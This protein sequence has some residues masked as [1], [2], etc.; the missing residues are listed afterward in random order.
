VK[1]VPLIFQG[2]GVKAILDGRKT[3]TRRIK[4]SGQPG[5]RIWVKETWRDS[6]NALAAEAAGPV[7]GSRFEGPAYEYAADLEERGKGWKSSMFM[8]RIAARI[9]LE[10]LAVRAERIQDISIADIKA[11]GA[12]TDEYLDFHDWAS[13]VAPPGSH[14]QTLREYFIEGIWNKLNEGRGYGWEANPEV[15]AITFRMVQP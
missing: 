15:K 9:I 2:W 7:M 13:S 1:E 6:Y 3:M 11:E 8:P 10:I 12:E 4:F 5:D 14:I